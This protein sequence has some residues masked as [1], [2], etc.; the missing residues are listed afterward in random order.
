MDSNHRTQRDLIYSQAQLPLC[1]G[2]MGWP[3]GLE[4]AYLASQASASARL[5]S[6]TMSGIEAARGLPIG[7]PQD[8]R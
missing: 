7:V 6:A 3:A 5:A 2:R 4:P 8:G 1:H